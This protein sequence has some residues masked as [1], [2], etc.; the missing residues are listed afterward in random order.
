MCI[1]TTVSTADREASPKHGYVA[2]VQMKC[3]KDNCCP[4]NQEIIVGVGQ[5]H[6]KRGKLLIS[7]RYNRIPL[8]NSLPGG[9][10]RSWSYKTYPTAKVLLFFFLPNKNGKKAK[11]ALFRALIRLIRPQT[12]SASSE[13]LAL[14]QKGSRV[15]HIVP[16]PACFLKYVRGLPCGRGEPWGRGAQPPLGSGR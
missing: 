15:T 5:G 16:M 3:E 1:D 6:E 12:Y 9:F 10:C 11:K 14:A 8:L 13:R 7:H 2:Q 4:L